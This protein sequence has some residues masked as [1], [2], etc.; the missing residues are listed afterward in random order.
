MHQYTLSK[1]IHISIP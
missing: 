1:I